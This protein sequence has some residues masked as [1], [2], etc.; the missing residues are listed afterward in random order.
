MHDSPSINNSNSNNGRS[1]GYTKLFQTYQYP[2]QQQ[3][4]IYNVSNLNNNNNS[5]LSPY[6]TTQN[7]IQRPSSGY[8]STNSNY[9]VVYN[10]TTSNAIGA[11]NNNND[12]C[13][14]SNNFTTFNSLTPNI[15]QPSV[16][17][18]YNNN[19]DTFQIN[20]NTIVTSTTTDSCLL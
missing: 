2:Q 13:L 1:N 19:I 16:S 5:N 6:Y 15:D 11:N 9:P 12:Y 14:N 20:E 8:I 10:T 3:Q 17:S 18:S 4:I 7:Y